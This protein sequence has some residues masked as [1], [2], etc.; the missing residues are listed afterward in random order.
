MAQT[1]TMGQA[2]GTAAAL[3]VGKDILPHELEPALLQDRLR[4]MGAKFGEIPVE[5][6][7]RENSK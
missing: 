7:D 4:Q 5:R 1:M 2:A 6:N 3:A